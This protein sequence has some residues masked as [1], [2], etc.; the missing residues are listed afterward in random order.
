[1]DLLDSS[2]DAELAADASAM[3]VP[4]E[5]QDFSAAQ[6][7][8]EVEASFADD[9]G[10][11][12]LHQPWEVDDEDTDLLSSGAVLCGAF[13]GSG[14]ARLCCGLVEGAIGDSAPLVAVRSPDALRVVDSLS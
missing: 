1:M 12:A 5:Q 8:A 4:V 3:A 6:G 13:S 10:P 11:S 9:Q 2:S 14:G 7:K